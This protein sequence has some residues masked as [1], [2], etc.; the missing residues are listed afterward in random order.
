MARAAHMA[1]Q[2]AST[3]PAKKDRRMRVSTLRVVLCAL[4]VGIISFTFAY[5][6]AWGEKVDLMATQSSADV[7]KTINLETLDGD[8]F[9]SENLKDARVTLFNVWGTTCAPCVQELPVLEELSH[10]YAPGE[11]QIVGMLEDSLNA[12]GVLVPEHLEIAKGYLENAGATYPTLSLD[13]TTYAYVKTTCIGTPTTFFVDSD[14]NVVHVVTG[15]NSLEGWK[16][17]VDT[18]LSKIN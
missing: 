11:I 8:S 13:E 18:A 9:T 12:D 14:G 1:I 10:S 17:Q 16:E 4:I 7:F 6:T 15:A 3:K 5:T 2:P